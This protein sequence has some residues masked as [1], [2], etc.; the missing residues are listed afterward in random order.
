MTVAAVG[1]SVG[2]SVA[3]VAAANHTFYATSEVTVSD[4]FA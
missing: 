3:G 1:A 4:D 2:V